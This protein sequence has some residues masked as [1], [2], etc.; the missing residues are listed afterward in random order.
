MR[1]AFTAHQ[2][3]QFERVPGVV[4][5]KDM[6]YSMPRLFEDKLADFGCALGLRLDWGGF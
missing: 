3:P 2:L 5:S 4:V 1:K 6:S